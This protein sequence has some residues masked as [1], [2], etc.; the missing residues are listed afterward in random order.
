MKNPSYVSSGTE[1]ALPVGD[2]DAGPL[3]FPVARRRRLRARTP[4]MDW[5]DRD[6]QR[7]IATWRE[8]TGVTLDPKRVILHLE[9]FQKY[10]KRR[11]S[12]QK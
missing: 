7:I 11:S 1:A 4:K 12:W 8:I 6:I 3:F 10:Q 5:T 9:Q 2:Q